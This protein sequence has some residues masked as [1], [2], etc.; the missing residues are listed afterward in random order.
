AGI[1]TQTPQGDRLFTSLAG[2][3]ARQQSAG[4]VGLPKPAQDAVKARAKRTAAQTK[5]LRDYFIEYAHATTRD[6]F[7]PLHK[8]LAGIE[9][10]RDAL[11]KQLPTTL[12]FRETGRPKQ[13]YVLKR[14]E[15]DQRADPVGR[16]TPKFLPP[17]PA[18][19]PTNRLG[20]AHWLLA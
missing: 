9:K 16:A 20:L 3:L 10:G 11:D 4:G 2:W 17:L 19:E 18:G 6:Q 12:V 7:A 1:N 14:G 13:A 15:Y 8:E 5:L